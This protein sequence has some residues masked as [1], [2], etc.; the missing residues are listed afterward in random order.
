MSETQNLTELPAVARNIN[1]ECKK[2]GVDRYHVV[3]AHTT[4]T[5]A[6]VKCEV[7]GAQKTFKLPK[8]QE[9]K[10]NGPKRAAKK[11]KAPDHGAVWADLKTQIGTD[12]LLPYDMKKKFQLANAINHP[13]FG[14]GFVTGATADRIEVAFQ[15]GGRALVHNRP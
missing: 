9:R 10:S 7:C 12:K 14:I 1:L 3:V 4:A 5:S 15:E 6:K 13:K 11:V 8:A 2:C